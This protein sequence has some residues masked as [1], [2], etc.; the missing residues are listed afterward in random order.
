MDRDSPN[1]P[2]HKVSIT[3][4]NDPVTP[5]RI[6]MPTPARERVSHND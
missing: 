2:K 4:G 5:Q 6:V 3:F 1:R